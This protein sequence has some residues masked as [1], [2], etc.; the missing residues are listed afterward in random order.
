MI[1]PAVKPVHS[2]AVLPGGRIRLGLEQYGI[3]SEVLDAP[4]GH[5]AAARAR[6]CWCRR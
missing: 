2:P 4:D 3:A 5:R 6:P 1:R